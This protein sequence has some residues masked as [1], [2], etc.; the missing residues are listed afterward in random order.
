M[1]DGGGKIIVCDPTCN[2]G[3]SD[4]SHCNCKCPYTKCVLV[5]S[6]SRRVRRQFVLMCAVLDSHVEET[7]A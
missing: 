2:D 3:V 1:Y 5:S 6:E 7:G 4:P